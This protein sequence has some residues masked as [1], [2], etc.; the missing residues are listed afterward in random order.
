ME[1]L[2]NNV[3]IF[4]ITLVIIYIMKSKVSFL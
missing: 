3:F 1:P 2:E 4:V